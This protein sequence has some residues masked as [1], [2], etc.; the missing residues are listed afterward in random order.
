MHGLR[1][2]AP[3]M[4]DLALL[5][6]KSA[7]AA[8]LGRHLRR[9]SGKRKRTA[10]SIRGD[11]IAAE[12][13]EDLTVSERLSRLDHARGFDFSFSNEP[14]KFNGRSDDSYVRETAVLP[15]SIRCASS[16]LG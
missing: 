13:N 5:G 15:S 4:P 11:R 3:P 8:G 10:G 7:H 2:A 16:R 9:L 6:L 1:S 12:S 14:L